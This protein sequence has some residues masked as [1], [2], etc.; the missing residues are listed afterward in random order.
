LTTAQFGD[1][2]LLLRPERIVMTYKLSGASSTPYFTVAF[3]GFTSAATDFPEQTS[4]A[5]VA[6]ECNTSTRSHQPYLSI[7]EVGVAEDLVIYGITIEGTIEGIGP[8]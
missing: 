2:T 7:T 3:G 8:S 5:T 4:K 6:C 1:H